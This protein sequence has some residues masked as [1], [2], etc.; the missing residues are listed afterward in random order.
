MSLCNALEE[1]LERK[2]GKGEKLVGAVVN[3]VGNN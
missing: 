2:E 3:E 1:K